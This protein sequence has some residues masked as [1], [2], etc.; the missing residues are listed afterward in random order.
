MSLAK[1]MI[2]TQAWAQEEIAAQGV[3]LDALELQEQAIRAAD[4]QA[5]AE[6]GRKLDLALK[7]QPTRD[8]RRAALIDAYARLFGVP[9]ATLTLTSIAERAATAGADVTKLDALRSELRSRVERV[10]ARSQTHRR[11][12]PL[13]PG[14]DE[15]R[16]A[17]TVRRARE[18]RRARRGARHGNPREHGGLAWPTSA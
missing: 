13:P 4:T 11:A 1:L 6:S 8:R 14:A 16:D 18:S 12:R 3:L 10:H 17:R 7:G 5:V 9:A 2:H 15:R